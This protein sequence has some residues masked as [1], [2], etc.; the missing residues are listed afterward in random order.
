M[1]FSADGLERSSRDTSDYWNALLRSLE[2]TAEGRVA[3]V[4]Q[5]GQARRRL[6][7]ARFKR[8]KGVTPVGEGRDEP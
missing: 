8:R 1:D 2:R 3:G 4:D 5:A 7:S 6:R